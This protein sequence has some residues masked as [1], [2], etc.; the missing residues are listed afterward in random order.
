MDRT[1]ENYP[2]G[3]LWELEEGEAKPLT[4]R[5]IFEQTLTE[6][7]FFATVFNW[8]PR[9]YDEMEVWETNGL[10]YKYRKMNQEQEAAKKPTRNLIRERYEYETAMK[11]WEANGKEG[12]VPIPPQP[13]EPE[14]DNNMATLLGI[15]PQLG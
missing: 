11:E 15:V 4:L 6:L 10:I 2:F 8:D 9:T 7:H 5:S 3:D 14:P 12:P 13:D 1:L